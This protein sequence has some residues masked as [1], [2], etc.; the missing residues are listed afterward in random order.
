[1]SGRKVVSK[2]PG[3]VHH[4]LMRFTV[5]IIVVLT[6]MNKQLK[7]PKRTWNIHLFHAVV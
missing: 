7:W 5:Q 1:M 3:A 4:M 6:G 2:E